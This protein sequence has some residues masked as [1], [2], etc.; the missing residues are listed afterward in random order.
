MNPPESCLANHYGTLYAERDMSAGRYRIRRD[1]TQPTCAESGLPFDLVS[2]TL[3]FVPA[4]DDYCVSNFMMGFD[5]YDF[6]TGLLFPV[7]FQDCDDYM[8][9][10]TVTLQGREPDLDDCLRLA[11]YDPDAFG[12][13]PAEKATTLLYQKL[14][15]E[16]QAYLAALH[17]SP[18]QEIIDQAGRITAQE[19]ILLTLE[20][21]S[22]DYP[23]AKALLQVDGL[24]ENLYGKYYQIYSPM[25]AILELMQT[26]AKEVTPL[27]SQPSNLSHPT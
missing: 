23:Q 26:Y 5:L 21:E 12:D 25:P 9:G 7:T 13:L 22:L 16:H 20:V 10:R 18:P 4:S 3:D 11:E 15:D 1:S 19:N 14:H 2:S 24:L 6:Y 17:R 27:C 8:A